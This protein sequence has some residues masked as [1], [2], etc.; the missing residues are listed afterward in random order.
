MAGKNIKGITIEINGSTTKLG[1]AL[2]DVTDYAK[3]SEKQLKEVEKALKLDPKNVELLTQKQKLLGNQIKSTKDRLDLLNAA[4]KEASKS[5]DN[6]D[7]WAAAYEPLQAE[8]EKTKKKIAELTA[9]QMKL[10]RAGKIDTGEYE[11]LSAE[12]DELQENL[13]DLRKQAEAVNE[14]FGNP[15]SAQ[16]YEKLQTDIVLTESKLKNLEDQQKEV[17]DSLENLADGANDA[18]DELGD[19]G[20]AA[21]DSGDGFTVVKGTL[22]D[23][24]T[25]IRQFVLSAISD[26]ISSLFELSEATEEYRTMQAKLAG[27][28]NTF[29]YSLDFASGQYQKFYKYLD[30]D[31][32]ATNAI[33]NLMGL[34][35]STENLTSLAD[36]AIAVWTAYGDS[37]PIE[38]LTESINETA[39]VG[40]VTGVLAD[41][42]NWAG[43]SEDYFNT[44]L[45][46][47]LNTQERA[48]LIAGTLNGT[49]AE[50]KEVYDS[51][52]G[53]I[54]NA[55]AAEQ[56]LKNTEAMLG[57]AMQPV[58]TALTELKNQILVA[59]AP[60]IIELA[61]GFADL[62]NWLKEH[63]TVIYILIGAVTALAIAFGILAV[64][65]AIQGIIA[66]VSSAFTGLSVVMEALPV[67]LVVAL[68][69][70]IV[71]AI[72]WLID[73]IDVLC[74]A[75][76][77]AWNS[78]VSWFQNA[79]DSVVSGFESLKN[80]A[81]SSFQQMVS[82][83][84]SWGTS[85]KN[86]AVSTFNSIVSS[87]MSWGSNLVNAGRNAIE[88]VR[89]A[90]SSGLERIKSLFKFEWSLPHI[91]LP[92]F[93]VSGSFSLNPPSVPSIGV[94]WYAKGGILNGAQIFGSMGNTL[95]GGGEA[96][97]EAVLPLSGF[98]DNLRS[99]LSSFIGVSGNSSTDNSAILDRLDGIYDR[100]GRLQVVLD[101]GTLVGETVDQYDAALAAKQR[102]AARGT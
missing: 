64:A 30:D 6:Y 33:T 42:L 68:I 45:S 51:L 26:L 60:L 89:S 44:Q 88:N 66:A 94:Q 49:Y 38:S 47:C 37:I 54:L 76:N 39:Q 77:E 96:G 61:Y 18:G 75:W 41:A 43:I 86:Q 52:N 1:K 27:S 57:E 17:C 9:E 5:L 11:N 59:L 29:G 31:Q 82:S 102:L 55:N 99:I 67:I 3:D 83:A 35:T 22:A 93:Y 98:Y 80:K 19:L 21:N 34:C 50:S 56:E 4:Q 63:P 65:M 13:K 74:E 53:S 71:A 32:A 81:V 36:G 92:H 58:N 84:V 14:E 15:I 23:L 8:I 10:E 85:M 20:D 12:I 91:K 46:K 40:K 73:N 78:M 79:K 72:I 16:E 62:L 97:P 101:T 87:A 2:K 70:A 7:D 25:E 24:V 48:N 69:A 100:L 90:L 95:L 28:A